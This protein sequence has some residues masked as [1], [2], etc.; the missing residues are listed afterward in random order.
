MVK[1]LAK[2]KFSIV[3]FVVV[4]LGIIFV[5]VPPA[6]TQ[7]PVVLNLLMTA[8]DAQPWKEGIIKDFESKNPGIRINII[9]GP[10]ATNL[11]EDL[12]TSAFIL[13]DSPY[14]LINMDVI[15]TPKF[16]AA[17]WLLDLTDKVT[18][19]E[20]TAFSPKDVEGGRYKGRLYRIPMRSDVG[21]LYY[22][23]DLLKQAGFNPPET[24]TDLIKISQALKQQ[25]KINWGYIW[26]G[27]QYEGLAA[28]F[29]E[30]LQ[31]FGGFW[32]NPNTLEVGLDRPET[33][34]AIAFLKETIATGISP[35]G[36]TTYQ[37]EET[38]RI[39]QSGQAVF[40]RSWPYVW[41][42]ANEKDSPIRGKIAIK[43]MVSAPGEN[44]GAC[45]GGWGLGISK[46]TKHPQ[47]AWKA[48]QYF[49]SEA[50]QRRFILQAGFVPSRRSLFTDPQIVA[51]YPHYPQLL[52]VV[53]Q[54]VLRP[55]IAQYAQTSDILQ[56]YLSAALTNRMTP[57]AAM[58]AAAQE[59]RRLLGDV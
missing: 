58:K 1:V 2:L 36:V 52:E 6:H 24:F 28:M 10:N 54:A 19:S 30:I 35:P 46:T 25:D 41:P 14:D 31:G 43:P 15:W 34:K 37:E 51:T 49:T 8:P 9:E 32:V 13:G 44:S 50:A 18:E 4:L 47:E 59:T 7:Q 53:E 21:M 3:I 5:S 12:Y 16:A 11:L 48:I 39:F 57:E 22:R 45:L 42:L 27:R 33:L 17:G 40:L 38:R 56:R 29:V 20:L 55:P 23:E 26:Q